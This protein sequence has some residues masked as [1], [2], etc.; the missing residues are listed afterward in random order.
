MIQSDRQIAW[1]C[2]KHEMIKPYSEKL[3]GRA[4][5]AISYGPSSYGYDI[6][7]SDEFKV[8]ADPDDVLDPKTITE[9][10]YRTFK[11]KEPV[12]IEPQGFMLGAS[13]E[14]FKM[15]R[16]MIGLATNKSTYARLGLDASK[17]TVLEPGWEGTLTIELSNHGQNPMV[18]HP[19][20]G[21]LQVLFFKAADECELSYEDRSGKYQLQSGVTI[22]RI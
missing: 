6:T 3:I 17:T 22:P 12:L 18:V 14:R 11:S 7:L 16:N 9:K 8:I 5:R 13:V 10:H 4:E 20:E 19:G 2:L 21:I 15:P 1:W